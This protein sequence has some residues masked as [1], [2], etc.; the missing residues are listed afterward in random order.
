MQIF[1]TVCLGTV[2]YY[3]FIIFEKIFSRS[4]RRILTPKIENSRENGEFL[5]TNIVHN[6]TVMIMQNTKC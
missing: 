6:I 3:R 5:L 4:A 1:T 2:K